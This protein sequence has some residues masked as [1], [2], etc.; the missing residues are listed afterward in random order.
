M[1]WRLPVTRGALLLME[2]LWIYALLGFVLAGVTDDSSLSILGVAAVVF[3]SYLISRAFEQSDMEL[4]VVRVWGTALSL[5]V[6]YA[7]VRIDLFGDWRF[8]DFSWAD[9]FIADASA[10]TRGHTAS[11]FGIAFLWIFWMR[12]LAR[13]QQP[14]G[15][16]SIVRTFASGVAIMAIVQLLPNPEDTPA[17]VGLVAVP[18]IAVGLLAIG[19]AQAARAEEEYGRSFS[20]TWVAA[21]GG[22][23]ILLSA[24]ALIFVLLDFSEMATGLGIAAKGLGQAFLL[25]LWPVL[26][27]LSQV[28]AGIADAIHWFFGTGEPFTPEVPPPQAAEG[29]DEFSLGQLPAWFWDIVRSVLILLFLA[30]VVAG[31][32]LVFRR[33]RKRKGSGDE[34]ESTYEE[35]RIAAELGGLFGSLLGRLRPNLHF[36]DR[37]EP[38]RRL[39]ADVL[40]A[41]A[42][43]GV[44][45]GPAQTPLELAPRLD[46]IFAAPTPGRITAV[47]DE[48]RYGSIAVSAE[49]IKRLRSEWE[50]LQKEKS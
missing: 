48:A 16:D 24:V 42:K 7:I 28:F 22:A 35:G 25:V 49:D 46:Q 19:L 33:N 6:F 37:T 2:T 4:G 34:A 9:R 10:A 45:R 14:M 26:W 18:Y 11:V 17:A 8:W 50:A 20:G 1:K 23:V 27:I 41:G 43:R 36:G 5:L 40:E 39:Y 13:G 31:A 3:I 12:G 32:A 15:F 29:N 47:F 38:V 44:S 30:L 21:V